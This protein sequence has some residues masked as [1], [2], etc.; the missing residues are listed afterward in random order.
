[1]T[2]EDAQ[3]VQYLLGGPLPEADLERLEERLFVDE[4]LFDHLM[5]LEDDLID[6][7]LRR[8][9]DPPDRERF[10]SHFLASRR[11]REKWEAQRE[12]VE[13]F[14]GAAQPSLRRSD[15]RFAFWPRTRWV[16]HAT[17]VALAGLA[18]LLVGSTVE[19][20]RVRREARTLR[21][22]LDAVERRPAPEPW[23][24]L[25]LPPGGLRGAG[26]V[27]T[28]VP[29]VRGAQLRLLLPSGEHSDTHYEAALE[30]AEGETL[31]REGRLTASAG[32]VVLHVPASILKSGDYVVS[33][34]D[35]G[36]QGGRRALPS[37]VFR[38]E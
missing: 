12:I 16:R 24:V 14:R 7:H 31:L 3:L 18:V 37:Y 6:A 20:S 5:E 4:R 34:Q 23:A 9:L 35:A 38:V 25:T 32:A 17:A 15:F 19:L 2:G 26:A 27:R 30:T 22:R 10:E 1:V 13:Y 29:S 28:F 21:D 36:P 8:A 11:R 33:L